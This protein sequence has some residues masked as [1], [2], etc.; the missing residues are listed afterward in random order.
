MLLLFL[1]VLAFPLG[2]ETDT[3]KYHCGPNAGPFS[4]DDCEIGWAYALL[5]VTTS[6]ALYCPVLVYFTIT[7]KQR[8]KQQGKAGQC[9]PKYM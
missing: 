4:V 7:D 3:V 2:F 8:K 9:L 5:I 1:C 6:L